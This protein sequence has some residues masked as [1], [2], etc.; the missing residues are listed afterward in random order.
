MCWS[1]PHTPQ[2]P[3]LIS[4]ALVGT[5]GHGTVRITG[6]APGPS[7]VATRVLSFGTL[8]SSAVIPDSRKGRLGIHALRNRPAGKTTALLP[9]GS[10]CLV[11]GA[12]AGV[13]L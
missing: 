4:A 2:A 7:K 11:K 8:T 13:A 6:G 5:S 12:Y 3:I 1:V 10:E 9:R